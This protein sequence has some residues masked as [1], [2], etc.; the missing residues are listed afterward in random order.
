MVTASHN[1]ITGIAFVI[2]EL[3]PNFPS[4]KSEEFGASII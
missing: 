2:T 4:Q 1:I 3:L